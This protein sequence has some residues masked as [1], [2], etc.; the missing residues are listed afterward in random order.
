MARGISIAANELK[1]VKP[2]AY[3]S[4]A[5]KCPICGKVLGEWLVDGEAVFIKD[6]CPRCKNRV[7]VHKKT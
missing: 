2:T 3:Q 7:E 1:T 4:E 5:I 6:P